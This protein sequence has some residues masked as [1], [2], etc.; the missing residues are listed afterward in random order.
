MVK[1]FQVPTYYSS[2]LISRIKSYY[3]LH[4]RYKKDMNP[5]ILDLGKVSFKLARHFGFCY[6]VKNAIE[7][8]YQAIS[9]VKQ[10]GGKQRIF[11]LSEII[12]NSTVNNDLAAKGI[13]F[14]QTEK[15]QSIDF[16]QLKKDDIVI[17][18]AFGTEIKVFE[19]LIEL[20][21]DINQY[22]TT[23]PFVK[24]VW[25]RANQLSKQGYTIIVHGQAPHEETRATFSHASLHGPTLIVQNREEALI[26]SQIIQGELPAQKF[27]DYFKGH[28]SENFKFP[29][30]LTRIGLVNQTTMLA[31]ET[32]KIGSI[33][34]KSLENVLH[35]QKDESVQDIHHYYADTH[36]T[37]CYATTE[38]Q[39][40]IYQTA[41]EPADFAIIVGGYNSSNT[42]HLVEILQNHFPTYYIKNATEILDA[43]NIR[44]FDIRDKKI[45]KTSNW[46]LENKGEKCEIILSAGASC[47]DI[48]IDQ[49]IYR[50]LELKGIDKEILDDVITKFTI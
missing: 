44:H 4:D 8:A 21:I 23:C 47:P 36:D 27:Q 14:L 22:D 18:P 12:H 49:V 13:H 9:D 41:K 48:L 31:G 34:K 6:G 15:S 7:L 17:I 11:L 43:H 20:G 1:Q 50:I 26:L 3:E 2:P 24:K 30:H 45:R 10:S 33:L 25:N 37:L 29:E 32:K 46:L 40:A 5:I 19:K 16:S 38:N 39:D 35:S 28:Y 42:T